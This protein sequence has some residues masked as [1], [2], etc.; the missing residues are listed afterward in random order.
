MSYLSK[1]FGCSFVLIGLISSLFYPVFNF[2]IA[3]LLLFLVIISFVNARSWLVYLPFL[4]VTLDLIPY[5][6]RP[7]FNELDF[8]LLV[9]I[10]SL[11]FY[12]PK[13][14][15]LLYRFIFN[16]VL[17]ILRY[18]FKFNFKLKIIKIHL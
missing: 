1:I 2:E 17:Y 16:Y 3:M 13:L 11:F 6:G 7:I 10:G 18:I 15:S 12:K 14:L 4:L 5:S 8:I 9:T